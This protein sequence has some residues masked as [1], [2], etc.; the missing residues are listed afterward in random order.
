MTSNNAYTVKDYQH[1][2]Q[3]TINNPATSNAS[4]KRKELGEIIFKN[5]PRHRLSEYFTGLIKHVCENP[6]ISILKVKNEMTV[7]SLLVQS[8]FA[9]LLSLKYSKSKKNGKIELS[10]EVEDIE[11]ELSAADDLE[12]VGDGLKTFPVYCCINSV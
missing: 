4:T 1:A 5:I 7:L 11:E 2:I 6:T 10:K 12:S 3:A 8:F 9:W